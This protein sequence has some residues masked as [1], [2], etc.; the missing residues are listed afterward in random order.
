MALWAVFPDKNSA[1]VDRPQAG[2]YNIREIAL[3]Q[4]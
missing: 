2:G 3:A 4:C 1:E